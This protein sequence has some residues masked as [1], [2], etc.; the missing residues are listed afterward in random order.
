[1]GLGEE[2]S[3]GVLSLFMNVGMRNCKVIVLRVDPCL[4]KRA[5]MGENWGVC[6]CV[7]VCACLTNSIGRLTSGF[8]S[9]RGFLFCHLDCHPKHAA[10]Y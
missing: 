3:I 6:V 5:Y 7:C 9:L 2:G 1:M 4:K 10:T 8:L